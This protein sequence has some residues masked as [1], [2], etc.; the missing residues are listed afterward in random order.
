MCLTKGQWLQMNATT[1]RGLSWKLARLTRSPLVDGRSKSGAGVPRGSML[2]GVS[3]METILRSRVSYSEVP[4]TGPRTARAAWAQGGEQYS[5][6]G[7]M[8][9]RRRLGY[10]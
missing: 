7:G 5:T 4:G 6:P 3:A 8:S 10:T 9:V 1:S 2:D